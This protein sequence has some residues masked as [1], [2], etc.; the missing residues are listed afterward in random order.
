M[1]EGNEGS[2]GDG[3]RGDDEDRLAA[4]VREKNAALRADNDRLTEELR[5]VR[6]RDVRAE[7]ERHVARGAIG[8]SER[9][10]WVGRLLRPDATAGEFREVL[11]GFPTHPATEGERGSVGSSEAAGGDVGA[12]LERHGLPRELA[13]R[14]SGLVGTA[15]TD[16]RVSVDVP[17]FGEAR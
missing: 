6:E 11:E 8:A 16:G 4:A 7:V 3:R 1:D 15:A 14:V 9:D 2:S 5:A 12:E 17:K 13:K 10:V